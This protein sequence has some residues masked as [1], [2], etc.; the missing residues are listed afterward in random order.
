MHSAVGI[1]FFKVFFDDFFDFSNIIGISI[2]LILFV[3]VEM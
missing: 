1:R 3:A 2:G